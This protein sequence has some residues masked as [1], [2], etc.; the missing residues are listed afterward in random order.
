MTL[1]L[2][3]LSLPESI[4][5]RRI[6]AVQRFTIIVSLALF[7]L[8]PSLF[9]QQYEPSLYAGM[10]WRQIGPFRAGRVTDVSGAPG[11]P[12]IYYMGT[13]GGGAWKTTDGGM[14]WKPIFDK[15]HVASIG[16]I[17][18]A[19]SNPNIV[20]IGTGDVSNVGAR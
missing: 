15:E 1:A 14:V 10:Q 20:Y 3:S 12:A 6:L 11:Q 7:A 17:A 2:G 9:A 8:A 18:V 19:P 13:A 5:P 16:A 4:A